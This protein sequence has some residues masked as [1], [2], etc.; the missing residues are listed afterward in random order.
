MKK[1]LSVI[2]TAAVV[3]SALVVLASCGG[4]TIVGKWKTSVDYDKLSE[5]GG[6]DMLAALGVDLSG[7]KIDMFLDFKDDGTCNASI[8]EE[9]MKSI[10]KDMYK[11]M[12]PSIIAMAGVSEEEYYAQIGV[13]NADAAIEKMLEED[14]GS[15]DFA[16]SANYTYENGKLTIDSFEY[17]VELNGDKLVFTDGPAEGDFITSTVLPLTFERQ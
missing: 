13:D 3:L 7:K 5:E 9:Q 6:G 11:A 15:D 10:M 12:L 1:V 2:I 14:G 4:G 8:D 17:K 16:K